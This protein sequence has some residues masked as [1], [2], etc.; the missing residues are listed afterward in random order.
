MDEQQKKVR[1][2]QWQE[3]ESPFYKRWRVYSTF[4]TG[5]A[6]GLFYVVLISERDFLWLRGD[7]KYALVLV[8]SG[9]LGGVIYTI[10]VDG[11]VEMPEFVANRGDRFRAGLFGDILL[12]I[13][14]AIVLDVIVRAIRPDLEFGSYVEVAA[15]GIVG[16]YGGRAILQFALQRVFKDVNLLEADR[17]AYLQANMQRRLDRVDSLKLIDLVNQQIRVGL[18]GDE[19]VALSSE[20]EAADVE[21]RQRIFNLVRDFR[22]SAKAAE[23]R[24]RIARMIPLFEALIKG[25]PNQ[26]AYYAE[27]AF[28][29]KDSDST[30]WFKAI[31]YLDK[32]IALRGDKQHAETWDYELS[33]AITRIEATYQTT[34]S[35]DFDPAVNER[36][37]N[38]LL[39]VAEIYN[40]EN[41]LKE[42]SDQ[43]IPIPVLNWMQ[44]NEAVLTVHPRASKLIAQLEAMVDNE[45]ASEQSRREIPQTPLA[46][47]TQKLSQSKVGSASTKAIDKGIKPIRSIKSAEFVRWLSALKQAKTTGASRATARQDGLSEGGVKSSHK[48]AQN[49]WIRVSPLADRFCLIGEKFN[50]PPELL[51]AIAS[52]ESRC[53]NS[54]LLDRGWGDHGQAFGVMQVAKRYHTVAGVGPDPA[55]LEHL[56]QAAR[57]FSQYL[58]EVQQHHPIWSDSH[59]LEGAAVAY[60]SGVTNVRTQTG[61]NKGTTGNDYGADVIARAQ[62]YANRFEDVMSTQLVSKRLSSKQIVEEP[63]SPSL[64][65]DKAFSL[66]DSVGSGGKNNPEDVRKVKERLEQLGFGFFPV[67]DKKD[68]GLVDAINL[69]QSIIYGRTTRSGDGRIDVNGRTHQFLQASNAPQWIELPIEGEGFVNYER[70]FQPNDDHDYGVSWMSDVLITVGQYYEQHYRKGNQNVALIAINDVSRPEG[71]WTP[72]HS[73]HECGNAC[74][75]LLPHRGGKF[76]AIKWRSP[77]YDQAATRAQLKALKAQTSVSN[78]Y[79]NDPQLRNEGLCTYSGGHDDH[80]HFE[81]NALS[82]Q[83]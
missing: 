44:Q 50:L 73:G 43:N 14:G 23:E 27:L 38:D 25:N 10:M 8:F 81:I 30:D 72:D 54:S 48:M 18:V 60:N 77:E 22:L 53:G 80:I 7:A 78:I 82:L 6:I 45:S 65:E 71:G 66:T 37:I 31:E 36:I 19:L 46:N 26:H 51:A 56:E 17:I 79:F 21:V 34:G 9:I 47:K 3:Y 49:D 76:G 62:F 5:F 29:H 40:L 64:A 12:G 59:L 68:Q 57:I 61:M 24:D 58:K 13:A 52:R 63:V 20:I 15:A 16:G 55:S 33:R 42:V 70:K 74:D 39:I 32:A 11:H 4:L 35:Y 67:N 28:A 69:F 1:V 41:I 75:L 2:E 83:S